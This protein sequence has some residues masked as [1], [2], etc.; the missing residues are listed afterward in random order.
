MRLH[1]KIRIERQTQTQAA[2]G[3][4]TTVR[5]LVAEEFAQVKPLRGRER[6]QSNQLEAVA[7]Y[8]FNIRYRDGLRESDVIVWN[9]IIFNI[10][11]IA[12]AGPSRRF[13]ALEAE[14][15]VGV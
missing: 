5:Q 14:R 8:Q 2:D 13:L 10:R 6:S 12:D 4:L 3:R 15:G 1:E 7:N 11:F 9:G